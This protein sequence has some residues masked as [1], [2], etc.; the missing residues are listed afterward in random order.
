VVPGHQ[1][2]YPKYE[3]EIQSSQWPMDYEI[4]TNPD[5]DNGYRYFFNLDIAK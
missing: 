3:K 5:A 2:Y 4:L 1:N